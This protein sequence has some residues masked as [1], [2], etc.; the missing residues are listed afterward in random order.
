[1]GKNIISITKHMYDIFVLSVILAGHAFQAGVSHPFK[2][3]R[4]KSDDKLRRN[5]ML[6]WWEF[7]KISFREEI[8]QYW[9]FWVVSS[10]LVTF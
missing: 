7:N 9:Q 10:S 4:G 6:D 1:M 8:K 2:G 3:S 5:K